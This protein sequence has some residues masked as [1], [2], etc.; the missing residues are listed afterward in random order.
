MSDAY[1]MIDR[2]LRNNLGSDDDYAEYSKALDSLCGAQPA[3]AGQVLSQYEIDCLA[4]THLKVEIDTP[5]GETEPVAWVEGDFDFARAIEQ[6]VLAK[7]V[8]QWLPIETA[9]Q[10]WG[11]TKFDVW[12][13]D[14]RFAD[15]W[16]GK[17]TYEQGEPGIVYQS[18][19]DCNGPVDSYVRNATHW[20]PL[21][22]PPGIV[23]EKGSA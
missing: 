11:V 5:V 2:F 15:C 19:Y 10:D 22:P 3:Q 1:D 9:P 21:P 23:G 13:N 8:P 20:M 18:D 7:R 17:A 6:S 4:E 12:A 14:A 16:W